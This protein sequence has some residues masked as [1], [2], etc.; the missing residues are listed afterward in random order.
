M[1][2]AG[3]DKVERDYTLQANAPRLEKLLSDAAGEV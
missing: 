1:G 2:K 3:R